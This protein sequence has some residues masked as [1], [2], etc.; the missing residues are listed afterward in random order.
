M[1]TTYCVLRLFYGCSY[2]FH[3]SGDNSR[4]RYIGKPLGT[5]T[6]SAYCVDKKTSNQPN[7]PTIAFFDIPNIVSFYYRSGT[8]DVSPP[9]YTTPSDRAAARMRREGVAV[10]PYSFQTSIRIE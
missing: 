2:R 8:Y 9:G 10:D 5:Y 4:D 7:Q 3:L 6:A 1:R